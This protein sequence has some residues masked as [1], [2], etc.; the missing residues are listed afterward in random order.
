MKIKKALLILTA[1][2]IL[3]YSCSTKKT[4][5]EISLKEMKEV[6][7]D[8]SIERYSYLLGDVVSKEGDDGM[9]KV[10]MLC[11]THCPSSEKRLTDFAYKFYKIYCTYSGGKPVTKEE[12]VKLPE[13]IKNS[14]DYWKRVIWGIEELDYPEYYKNKY[15]EKAKKKELPVLLP[16]SRIYDVYSDVNCYVRKKSLYYFVKPAKI[17]P[18]TYEQFVN[19]NY[20]KM[21]E[22]I[23]T[24]ARKLVNK[25]DMDISMEVEKDRETTV[26]APELNGVVRADGLVLK[27]FIAKPELDGRITVEF[28]LENPTKNEKVFHLSNLT[29]QK[30]GNEFPVVY[31]SDKEGEIKGVDIKGK[32]CERQKKNK[33]VIKPYSSCKI[34]YGGKLWAKGIIIPGVED[35]DEGILNIDGFTL[36]LNK[37]TL[38]KY[39]ASRK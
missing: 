12:I 31:I 8:V 14:D 19:L 27:D 17:N 21:W 39:R 13:K 15:I 16:I 7:S 11:K 26:W 23:D 24:Y 10:K 28:T 35:L 9:Y 37:T 18:E 38:F 25:I 36:T 6:I 22:V 1:S 34:S 4:T 3:F 5:E 32:G 30:G 2:N 33:L 29:F 20:I